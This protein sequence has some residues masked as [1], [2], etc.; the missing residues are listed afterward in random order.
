MNQARARHRGVSTASRDLRQVDRLLDQVQ[1]ELDD[2]R[3]SLGPPPPEADRVKAEILP[4]VAQPP[5]EPAAPPPSPADTMHGEPAPVPAQQHAEP[6]ATKPTDAAEEK[7]DH[8]PPAVPADQADTSEDRA[9]KRDA[10]PDGSPVKPPTASTEPPPAVSVPVE[11]LRL[12][13]EKLDQAAEKLKEK[14]AVL[15]QWENAYRR[16]RA[17]LHRYKDMIAD[18]ARRMR[19]DKANIRQ[20]SDQIA[21]LLEHRQRVLEAERYLGYRERKM[22]RRWATH[23]AW[24]AVAAGLC[25]LIVLGALSFTI[26][27][28]FGSA[29]WLASGSIVHSPDR[30]VSSAAYVSNQRH[31]MLSSTV[32][33]RTASRLAEQG[34]LLGPGP[35]QSLSDYLPER[36]TLSARSPSELLIEL[37]STDRQTMLPILNALIPS[38]L[39][40]RRLADRA[41][42]AEQTAR[43]GHAPTLAPQ[44]LQDG[45]FSTSMLIFFVLLL[46]LGGSIYGVRW[47]LMRQDRLETESAEMDQL[48]DESTWESLRDPLIRLRRAQGDKS[49]A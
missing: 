27:H 49:A 6:A 44:P 8:R 10:P 22:Q 48:T 46:V 19:K 33:R 9:P 31:I 13:V 30:S 2:L 14:K 47:L 25:C 18:G 26:G 41:K 12:K 24:K 16:R 5:P 21:E 40:Q 7:P 38:Y 29:D 32:L 3:R 20:R 36:L 28:H 39:T 15:V 43:L 17:R 42:G 35:D 11:A 34:Y 1:A 23:R 37:H 45:R 4:E